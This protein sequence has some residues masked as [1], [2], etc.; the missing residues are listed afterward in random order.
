MNRFIIV[1]GLPYLYAEGKAYCVRWDSVGFTVGEEIELKSTPARIYNELSIKAQCA[2]RL[3]SIGADPEDAPETPAA[4]ENPEDAPETP[5]AEENPEDAP[6]TP[7][8]EQEEP[9]Q[10]EKSLDDMT[11]PELKQ[12]ANDHGIDIGSERKKAVIIEVIKNAEK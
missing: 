9:K 10:E 3:D 12:Y 5:A 8:A 6:E 2:S 7:A 4:E 11:I 1:D